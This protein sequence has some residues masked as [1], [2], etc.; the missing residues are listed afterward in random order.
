MKALFSSKVAQDS[1]KFSKKIVFLIF[2]KSVHDD[3]FKLDK[4]I[5]MLTGSYFFLVMNQ[6]VN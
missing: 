6:F 5:T 4:K 1:T 3:Y 2:S